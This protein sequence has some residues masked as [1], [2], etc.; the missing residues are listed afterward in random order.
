M[1]PIM[2]GGSCR[3]CCGGGGFTA[4]LAMHNACCL[5]SL[6]DGSRENEV[7]GEW[8]PSSVAQML[9]LPV[10]NIYIYLSSLL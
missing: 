8:K 9:K 5:L 7:I 1:I 6:L 10:R 3:C 2:V 4:E